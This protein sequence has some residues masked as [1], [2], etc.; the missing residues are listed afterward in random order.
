MCGCVSP[1]LVLHGTAVL[2]AT[3]RAFSRRVLA[4]GADPCEPDKQKGLLCGL[5]RGLLQPAS[6]LRQPLEGCEPLEA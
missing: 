2:F 1:H 3:Q 4:S 5:L 6:Y